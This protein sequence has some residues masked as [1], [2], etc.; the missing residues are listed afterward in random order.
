MRAPPKGSFGR[1][2][3]AQLEVGQCAIGRPARC[4]LH[5]LRSARA[6]LSVECTAADCVQCAVCSVQCAVCSVHCTTVLPP[7]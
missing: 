3:W 5:A 7:S 6:V 4:T 2:V 1:L